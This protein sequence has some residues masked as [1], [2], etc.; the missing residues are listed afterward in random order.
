MEIRNGDRLHC[1]SCGYEVQVTH[2]ASQKSANKSM[3]CAC[4]KEMKK[5]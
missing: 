5:K 1:E 3:R 2:E 4:G